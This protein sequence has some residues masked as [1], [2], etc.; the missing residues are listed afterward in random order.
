MFVSVSYIYTKDD[1]DDND[2]GNDD[3]NDDEED[4]D[5][6]CD[7]GRGG[8][9]GGENVTSDVD[10]ILVKAMAVI[11]LRLLLLTLLRQHC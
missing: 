10:N 8:G 2:D 9:C 4:A 5:D 1:N 11:L 6:G 3:V 7:G